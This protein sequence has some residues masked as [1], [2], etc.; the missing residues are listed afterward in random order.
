MDVLITVQGTN[1][2]LLP[3]HGSTQ[4]VFQGY[5]TS[6]V[7]ALSFVLSGGQST[8]VFSGSISVLVALYLS[9]PSIS[10]H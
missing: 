4:V 8:R 1:V 3:R 7:R 9:A 6:C 10:G 2:L 5:I